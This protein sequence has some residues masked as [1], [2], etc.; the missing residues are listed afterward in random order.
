[1]HK[2]SKDM[3]RV[4]TKRILFN[5]FWLS[6]LLHI[7]LFT[8]FTTIVLFPVPDVQKSHT[9]QVPAYVY[10]GTIKPVL[11][12]TAANE[13]QA[14]ETAM[15][16][17]IPNH[18]KTK[19]VA[20][21]KYGL[22]PAAIWSSTRSVLQASQMQAIQ[23]LQSSQPIYMIGDDNEAPDPLMKLVGQALSAN[24]KYPDMAGKF[25]I[26]GRVLVG[27]TLHPEGYFS[28]VAIVSSSH[29]SDLDSAALF[30]VNKA[31]RVAGADRFLIAPK[32]F[33][34]GFIFH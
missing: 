25:G 34:V 3:A 13:S 29:N 14:S 27:M 12:N 23:S 4:F 1:V 22:T 21:S 17:P 6:V 30:A 33:I 9:L 32:H 15:N 19:Q 28:H 11:Q 20:K 7:L 31:P 5:S 18:T 24:F 16:K 2:D 10:K 8:L 26:R